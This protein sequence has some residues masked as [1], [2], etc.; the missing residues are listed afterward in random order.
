MSNENLVRKKLEK[1]CLMKFMTASFYN[2]KYVLK[3]VNPKGIVCLHL[4]KVIKFQKDS[5]VFS[6][7]PKNK[8]T[9]SVPVGSG[10]K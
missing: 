2:I 10:K 1:M 6:I 8:R 9:I 3:M 7:L 4:L 5:L